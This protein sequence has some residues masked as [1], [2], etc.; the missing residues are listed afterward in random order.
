[1][2]DLEL[3]PEYSLE[4]VI[5]DTVR[6]T[7]KIVDPDPDSPDPQN[8]VLIPRNLMGWSGRAQIRKSR[9][10][11]AALITT[12]TLTGFGSDGFIYLYLPPTESKKVLRTCGWDLELTDPSGDVETILGGPVVPE[13]EYTQ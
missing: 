13:G 11:D 9:K 7:I 6:R 1:M 5:G 3:Y 8:P 12:L 10:K 2:A 4:F